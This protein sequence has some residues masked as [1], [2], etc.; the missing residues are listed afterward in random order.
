MKVDYG[1]QIEPQF[2]YDYTHISEVAQAAE[3][4]GFESL[5]ASD[6]F[7]IKPEA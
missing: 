1:V 6:H 4:H 7:M 3:K 2:G 5:W